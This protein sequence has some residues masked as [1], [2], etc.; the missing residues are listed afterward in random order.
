MGNDKQAAAAEKE[1]ENYLLLSVSWPRPPD[2][3]GYL[4]GREVV[5]AFVL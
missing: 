4:L 3:E 5:A 1:A 2:Q